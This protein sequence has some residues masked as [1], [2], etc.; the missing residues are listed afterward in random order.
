MYRK[1][2]LL[3][4]MVNFYVYADCTFKFINN[5]NHPV[6]LRANFQGV[7]STNNSD[8]ITLAPSGESQQVIVGSYKCNNAYMQAGQMVSRIDLRNNSGYWVGNKGF[9]FASDRSYSS[10][11][12]NASRAIA[13]DGAPITLSNGLSVSVKQFKVYICND[14]TYSDDCN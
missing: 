13:D 3:V 1:I 2:L 11:T 7:T 9:L 6:T 14:D 4:S 8:W 12:G 5:S 10:Y